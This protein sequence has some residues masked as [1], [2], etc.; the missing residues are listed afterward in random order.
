VFIYSGAASY[1]VLVSRARCRGVSDSSSTGVTGAVA[2]PALAKTRAVSRHAH[3]CTLHGRRCRWA[4]SGSGSRASCR[5]PPRPTQQSP[6]PVR[7]LVGPVNDV[8]V[9]SAV[10]S[11]TTR[12]ARGTAVSRANNAT[13]SSSGSVSYPM[14]ALA[15]H[16]PI[17]QE[18]QEVSIG[19]WSLAARS[20][21]HIGSSTGLRCCR[22]PKDRPLCP[23]QRLCRA[24]HSAC[25]CSSRLRFGRRRPV[26]QSVGEL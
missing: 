19:T 26:G 4:G 11:R 15:S 24:R 20:A 10:I 12:S 5:P 6:R 21:D 3:S 16:R 22:R 18:S 23:S 17:G 9:S 7:T 14:P 25:Q 1:R 2:M 13:A 8:L